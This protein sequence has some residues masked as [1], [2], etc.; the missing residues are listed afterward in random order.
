MLSPAPLN[1]PPALDQLAAIRQQLVEM[2]ASLRRM[3]QDLDDQITG[4]DQVCSPAVPAPESEA[5]EVA[6]TLFEF[7][8]AAIPAPVSVPP[9][10][11]SSLV[12][13]AT[14]PSAL[15]PQMEQA[16][17]EE[18]NAALSKAFAH[19]SERGAW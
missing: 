13:K 5:A 17:L 18:L 15:D 3:C 11:S 10:L 12:M 4:L 19:I 7:P 1:C 14:G 16:T 6:P 8:P 2:R 9:V